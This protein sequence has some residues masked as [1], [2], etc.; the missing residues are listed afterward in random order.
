MNNNHRNLILFNINKLVDE[1]DYSVLVQACLD[2]EILTETMRQIIDSDGADDDTR[3]TLLFEKL[4]HRGPTA[5]G[6]ILDILKENNYTTALKILSS[7]TIPS[8]TFTNDQA[9]VDE[10]NA[11]S[12][13]TTRRFNRN[14]SYSPPDN[15]SSP[16]LDEADA[17]KISGLDNDG[18]IVSK[19]KK[20]KVKLEPYMKATSFQYDTN[21]EVKRAVNFGSHSK[22]QVY[23]MRSKKRGVFFFVNIIKFKLKGED[24]YRNGAQ[25]DRENLVS[26]FREMNFTVFYYEDITWYEF[27]NLIGQLKSSDYLKTA[28]SMI[29]C[30]Q[31]H[32]EL[33]KNQTFMEFTDGSIET[34]EKVIEMFSN[35]NCK[36]LINKP[37]VFFFPFCRGTISDREK[38]ISEIQ[39]D[40]SATVPSYSDILICYATVPGFMTHRDTM[41]GSW[42]VRE[43]SKIFAEHAADSHIE[44]MLKMV[45]NKTMEIRAGAN[46]GRTQVSST[47]ARGFNK[48]MFLNPKISD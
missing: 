31:T 46:D 44:E 11:L 27:E 43:M 7:S 12:I 14:L 25:A 21:A 9:F 2:K 17:Q 16:K 38:K 32:G 37:K 5:F 3:N 28:D 33:I 13:S 4:T 19:P 18:P 22:L 39:T 24:K 41:F 35:V 10:T 30:V 8:A 42:Y 45:G 20:H 36:S 34:T 26:L 47:E 23:N 1:T 29:M 48:L 6:K 40:G 15:S